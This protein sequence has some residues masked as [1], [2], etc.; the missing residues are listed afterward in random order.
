[1][2]CAEARMALVGP[3]TA[4]GQPSAAEVHRRCPHQVAFSVLR[5]IGRTAPPDA[6][7]RAERLLRSVPV[8]PC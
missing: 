6:A 3:A 7:K 4:A 8:R 2:V 1:V 5:A